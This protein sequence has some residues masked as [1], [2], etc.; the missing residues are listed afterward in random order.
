MST[1]PILYTQVLF[2][3][4]PAYGCRREGRKEEGRERNDDAADYYNDYFIMKTG[5]YLN[6]VYM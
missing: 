2:S 4:P 6:A 3:E 1:W 5:H